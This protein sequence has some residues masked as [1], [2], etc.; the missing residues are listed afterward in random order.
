MPCPGLWQ[1]AQD[2]S[3]YGGSGGGCVV[4]LYFPDSNTTPGYSTLYN[5]TLDCGNIMNSFILER[6]KWVAAAIPRV[7]TAI[8]LNF[9]IVKLGNKYNN[10]STLDCGNSQFLF[11]VL[12]SHS[13]AKWVTC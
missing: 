7:A 12:S 13:H 11:I 1:Y 10:N 4:W 9:P 2:S 3:I 8:R 5:S 6:D